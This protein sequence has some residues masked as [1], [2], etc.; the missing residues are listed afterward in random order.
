[1]DIMV[2]TTDGFKI[3]EEDLRLRGPGEMAGVKQHGDL[4]FKIADLVQDGVLLEVSR[5]A[6]AELIERD[7]KLARPEHAGIR[8]RLQVRR[9]E[10]AVVAIS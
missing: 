10:L 2:G 4:D 7:P 5:Q 9:S 3:A 6:A 8:E 1:M